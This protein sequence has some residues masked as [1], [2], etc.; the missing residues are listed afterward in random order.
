MIDGNVSFAVV[1]SSSCGGSGGLFS[2]AILSSSKWL[3]LV[4]SFVIIESV[5]R[6]TAA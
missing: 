2:C 3:D 5:D 1:V 4:F 6:S